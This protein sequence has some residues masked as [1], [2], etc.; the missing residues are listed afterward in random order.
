MNRETYCL[1]EDFML[2]SMD[3]AAHDKEH[4][5]RVLYNALEIAKTEKAVDHDFLLWPRLPERAFGHADLIFQ[6]VQPAILQIVLQDGQGLGGGG[7]DDDL[8]HQV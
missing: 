4:I 1:L 5:Y 3:D 8:A 7:T 2:C 6:D